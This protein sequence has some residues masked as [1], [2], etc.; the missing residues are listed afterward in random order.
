LILEPIPELN[1]REKNLFGKA[2]ILLVCLITPR[3][4]EMT[5]LISTGREKPHSKL[6]SLR[7]G[8]HYGIC[9]WCKRYHDQ[10]GLLGKLSRAFPEESC[11][12]GDKL[13]TD[14]AKTRLKE[15]IKRATND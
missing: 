10:I 5:R 6:T 15:S 9:I 14:E 4:H 13:L 12:H 2:W 11:G 8:L 7:M 1:T 3:C